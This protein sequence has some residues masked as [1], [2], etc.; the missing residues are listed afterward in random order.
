MFTEPEDSAVLNQWPP[1]RS[2]RSSLLLERNPE[3]IPSTRGCG[4]R[5]SEYHDWL[6]G[7]SPFSDSATSF[8]HDR[9]S[10]SLHAAA[11][12]GQIEHLVRGGSGELIRASGTPATR[13][14]D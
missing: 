6:P 8:P 1:G 3:C 11:Y 2:D 14:G 4:D 13:G 12:D 10:A 9:D 7:R 5:E